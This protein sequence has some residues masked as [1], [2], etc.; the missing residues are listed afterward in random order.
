MKTIEELFKEII[1][2][3]DLK[4]ELNSIEKKQLSE[5]ETFLKKNGCNASSEDFIKY[6]KAVQEGEVEDTEAATVTGGGPHIWGEVHF[7]SQQMIP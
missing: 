4:K 2:S 7:V 3:E 5:I 6:V 1:A